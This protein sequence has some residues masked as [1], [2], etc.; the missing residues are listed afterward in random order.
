MTYP[1]YGGRPQQPGPPYQQGP[2]RPP[3][4]PPQG[5]PPGYPPAYGPPPGGPYPPPG[6]GPP[7]GAP[8]PRRNRGLWSGLAGGL[9]AAVLFAVTAF[10]YPGFLLDNGDEGDP[11]P[12]AAAAPAPSSSAAATT[13]SAPLPGGTGIT[14][15]DVLVQRLNAAFDSGDKAAAMALMCADNSPTI[16]RETEDEV[17]LIIKGPADVEVGPAEGPDDNMKAVITGT[18]DGNT[19]QNSVL[20]ARDRGP[21]LCIWIFNLAW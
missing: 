1:Q 18:V 16:T 9:G 10:G 12:A 4:H 19:L 6:Y 5:Y 21:G 20:L 15:K 2:G 14:D 17:D 8:P 7:P 3:G 11:E 13:T